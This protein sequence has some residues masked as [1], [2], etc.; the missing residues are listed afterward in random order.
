MGNLNRLNEKREGLKRQ[1]QLY[2]KRC[3]SL[4]NLYCRLSFYIDN[5][6][7]YENRK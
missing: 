5:Q 4:D 6:F 3:L 2:S 7:N 1:S